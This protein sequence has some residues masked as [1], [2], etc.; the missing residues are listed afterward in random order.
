MFYQRRQFLKYLSVSPFPFFVSKFWGL[1][2]LLR[3][4]K[5]PFL[6]PQEKSLSFY[7][8][9]TG[10]WLK[11]CVFW[12]DGQW[13]MEGLS[14]INRLFRDHRSGHIHP[15]DPLLL[16]GLFNIQKKLET[17]SPFHLISGYRSPS[18]NRL[19][20]KVSHGVA[21][22]SQHLLGKAADVYIEGCDL[23][24]IQKAALSLHFGGVGR[25]HRFVHLD[26]GKVRKW[27]LPA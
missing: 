1:S 26:T 24:W 4:S 22:K 11:K 16:I 18:T 23:R 3:T 10:E 21:F 25:Y 13:E 2:T 8:P 17:N 5:F 15:I 12:G 20:C 27:G 6:L 7:N 9:H 14:K 19:L